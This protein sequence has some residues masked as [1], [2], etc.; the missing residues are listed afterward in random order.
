M[1]SPFMAQYGITFNEPELLTDAV[2]QIKIVAQ[3]TDDEETG[4][5][6]HGWDES[7]QQ[8]WANKGNRN[9][10][11]F[12]VAKHWLVCRRR[13]GRTRFLPPHIEGTRQSSRHCQ[14]PCCRH[15]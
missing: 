1:V 9:V 4:L 14:H 5:F 6:Y 3:H 2:N 12:L 11:Q 7:K 8:R 10:A 15:R 13:C